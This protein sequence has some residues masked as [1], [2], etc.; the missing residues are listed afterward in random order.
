[1]N[2]RLER[3]LASERQRPF[4]HYAQLVLPEGVMGDDLA[5]QTTPLE[6]AQSP[7][8]VLGWFSFDRL[9]GP[10]SPIA[11]FVGQGGPDRELVKESLLPMVRDFRGRKESLS[12]RYE[13]KRD[14][15]SVS[16]SIASLALSL[17]SEKEVECL[18]ACLPRL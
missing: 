9:G 15:E 3:L 5:V 2:E 18:R 6:L 14:T 4:T 16:V 17:G 8:G 1:M 10:E 7:A 13:R 12:Q 11:I